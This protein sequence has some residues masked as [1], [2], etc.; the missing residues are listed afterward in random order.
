MNLSERFWKIFDEQREAR[1]GPGPGEILLTTVHPPD[2]V[3][4]EAARDLTSVVRRAPRRY[5]PVVVA[6]PGCSSRPFCLIYSVAGNELP[7]FHELFEQYLDKNAFMAETFLRLRPHCELPYVLFLGEKSFF[8]YD[9]MLEELLRW[10]S[11]FTALEELFLQPILAGEN[12]Q[13]IWN[14]IP[15]KSFAQRSEEFARW[16][17]LWKAAIGARTNA[18]PAFMQNL[19]QKV[20]LLFLFDLYLGFEDWD[21]R[22]RQIFLDQHA[23][24]SVKRRRGTTGKTARETVPFD[25]VAWLHESSDE[26]CRRYHVDFLFWTQAESNFFALINSEARQQFS[27]FVLGLYLLSQCKFNVQVQADVFSDSSSRLKLWKF[28]VTETLNI[29]RRLQADEINVYEPIYIDLE[30]SGI[31]W[32]LNVVEQ[33]LEFWRERCSYFAQQLTERR[34]VRVQFDMFQQPDLEHARVPLPQNVLETAFGTSL[35]IYYDFPIERATLEYLVLVKVL[36]FCRTW[37][38]PLQPLD[39]IADIFVPKERVIRIEEL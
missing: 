12:V 29:K 22:L 30:E 25:G 23:P 38:L 33:T 15:R 16:L 32:A 13:K 9:A 21:L 31:G 35:R 36:E 27:E 11:D 2:G 3:Q 4:S 19:M 10:G 6:Q 39:S 34:M 5:P 1:G 20:I 26:L 37:N 7:Q 18:T 17:D 24:V 8:L 14:E 28:S